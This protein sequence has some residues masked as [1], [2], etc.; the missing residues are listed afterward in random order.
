MG[1]GKRRCWQW[2]TE[3]YLWILVKCMLRW[4]RPIP[5][6]ARNLTSLLNILVSLRFLQRPMSHY[7][8]SQKDQFTNS[9]EM[10]WQ[11]C[12]SQNWVQRR[13]TYQKKKSQ[14]CKRAHVIP[15]ICQ[16]EMS[17]HLDVP[18]RSSW[19][20]SLKVR[21][22]LDATKLLRKRGCPLEFVVTYN[23]H[24]GQWL[25]AWSLA[26]LGGTYM[27]WKRRWRKCAVV[28]FGLRVS[29]KAEF[30]MTANWCGAKE[31]VFNW[32]WEFKFES[33]DE[34][35]FNGNTWMTVEKK[36]LKEIVQKLFEEKYRL[37][38]HLEESLPRKKTFLRGNINMKY[39]YR[40]T[41]IYGTG[42][43]QS[44]KNWPL[45]KSLNISEMF[46]L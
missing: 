26:S 9:M 11:R 21:V 20:H 45:Y 18:V 1:Q 15:R 40:T 2:P 24:C 10:N 19:R 8:L 27:H 29:S 7:C 12:R 25:Q 41:K 43:V 23:V 4:K 28:F 38:T 39:A 30:C 6:L 46:N 17:Y 3:T 33:W 31:D 36:A 37:V 5:E 44:V 32:G 22:C 34:F 14:N 13:E 35:N 42:K 16:L